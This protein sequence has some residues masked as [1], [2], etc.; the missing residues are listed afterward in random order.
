MAD[1]A[2]FEEGVYAADCGA[3]IVATTLCGFTAETKYALTPALKL[4]ERLSS[5]LKI[6]VICEGGISTPEQAARAFECGAFAVVIG[7]AITG[8]DALVRKFAAA[9]PHVGPCSSVAR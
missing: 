7:T 8:V 6:P 4:V 2:T 3:D 1:I 9:V 5:S